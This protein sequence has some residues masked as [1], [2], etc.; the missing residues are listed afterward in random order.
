MR[1]EV[2]GSS[3]F[4]DLPEFLGGTAVVRRDVSEQFADSYDLQIA[5]RVWVEKDGGLGTNHHTA[6]HRQF[7]RHDFIGYFFK[8]NGKWHGELIP[9]RD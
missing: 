2:D 4:S 3:A 1:T 9:F 6:D 5:W 7:E 8:E